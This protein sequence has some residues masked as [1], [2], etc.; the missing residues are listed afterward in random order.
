MA[1]EFTKPDWG[2]P[3]DFE[4]RISAVP[5]NAMIK[6]QPGVAEMLCRWE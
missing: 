4:A 2:S 1:P 5:Q 6:E 3:L